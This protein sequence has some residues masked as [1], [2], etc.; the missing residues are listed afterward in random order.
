MRVMSTSSMYPSNLSISPSLTPMSFDPRKPWNDLPDLPPAADIESKPLLK[1]C[2]EARAALAE[3]KSVGDL[4][5]NQAVLINNIPLLA[6]KTSREIQNNGTPSHEL[7]PS[8]R[9]TSPTLA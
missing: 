1:A 3:L 5:P 8:D 6:A 2:I 7:Y 9:M 4:I